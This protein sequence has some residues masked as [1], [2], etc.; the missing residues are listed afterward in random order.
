[1]TALDAPRASGGLA[2]VPGRR[3]SGNAGLLTLSVVLGLG[4]WSFLSWWFGP[5]AI[6]SPVITWKALL[7]LTASGQLVEAILISSQRIL[8]GWGLGVLVGAPLG[9]LMGRFNLVRQLT[10]PYIEFFRFIPPTAFVTLAVIW[11]GIGETSK[12]FLIFYT[13]VFIVTV[14]TVAAVV[15]IPQNRLHAAQNLGAS[16]MQIMRTVVLPSA[17]P[18]LLTG[19][20]IAMGNSFLTIVAAEIVAAESGLGALIWQARNYG[21]IDWTFVAIIVMGV[22]GYLFDRVLRLASQRWLARYGVRS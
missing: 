2:R 15:G 18:G 10:D 6:A 11:F 8:L 14:S 12:V 4:A 17:V 3:T 16:K 5:T 22:L 20:R 1:M 19:A 7:E 9:I 21:R 13:A